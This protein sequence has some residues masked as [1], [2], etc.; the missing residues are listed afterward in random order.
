MLQRVKYSLLG[1]SMVAAV[2]AVPSAAT[3]AGAQAGWDGFDTTGVPTGVEAGDNTFPA[4]SAGVTNDLGGSAADL[5]VNNHAIK[6]E[7][8][9]DYT[10][11][12]TVFADAIPSAIA[13]LDTHGVTFTD[14]D[15]DGD[16]DLIEV[17]GRNP[18][19]GN[20]RNIV[21]RNN[22]GSLSLVGG[23]TG[24]EDAP[25]RGRHAVMVDIDLDGDMDAMI[26]NLDRTV[27]LDE[28]DNPLAA[29]PSELYLNNGDGTSWTKAADPSNAIGDENR[30]FAHV[31]S[32]GPGTP[33]AVITS[34]AFGVALDS[35][36]IGSATLAE[37][38]TP[39]RQTA[40]AA[41]NAT[42]I[43]DVA[44]G[45]LDGDLDPEFV[46]AR[47]DDF[48]NE[49]DLLGTL[50]I[51]VGQITRSNLV[52]L[53]IQAV[54]ND[55]L[56][57]SCRAVALADFD[58]DQ[59]LDIFG[60]CTFQEE[61]QNRNIVLLN[62]GSGN[63]S[64]ASSTQVP[65]TVTNTT[66][67]VVAGDFDNNGWVDTYSATGHD[68]QEGPDH[69][70]MNKGGNGNHWLKVDLVATNNPDAV[71][72][73]V[74]VGT[75]K[76]QVRE[77]GHRHHQG[78]DMRELHFGLGTNTAVAPLEIRWPDGTHETCTVA[79]VDRTVTVTQGGAGCVAQTASGQAA[80]LA[81]SP[82]LDKFCQG[83]LVTVD[84][85]AGQL[86]TNGDDVILGTSGADIVDAL[87]GNDLVCGLDGDD[88]ITGGVGD[89]R[90]YGDGGLDTVNGGDGNDLIWGGGGHD[91]LFGDGGN[92]VLRGSRGRDLIRG[93]DGKDRLWGQAGHDFLYGDAGH[94]TLL[95]QGGNDLMFGGDGRDDM[96]GIQGND[97][98]FGEGGAD[99]LRGGGGTNTL[100]GGDSIDACFRG[101]RVNCES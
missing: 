85:G 78:Q 10:G 4:W 74:F 96:W 66:T 69:L 13:D 83:E 97:R 15:G 57:D 59:D 43:R 89:D 77:S 56:A 70:F 91:R 19:G 53:A 58:N 73:Q 28:D 23:T 76:W 47:Q 84:L 63:F 94:D 18:D 65:A 30:R 68:N 101:S 7:A 95:G 61:G 26:V 9:I 25:G 41:N 99:T 21:W 3:P 27:L 88:Q 31:T 46:V 29:A 80:A 52:P 92:D 54:S 82:S 12:G 55:D 93:G 71:G 67:V 86:P 11:G 20:N 24:L 51:G 32:S 33:N 2:L 48:N 50:P 90:L 98:M 38:D 75:D 45:D 81:A 40:F 60:G 62:D 87:G 35:I 1:L 16:E 100:D 5:W 44:L 14:I 22:N 79:G 8:L 6:S 39:I 37:S 36:K 64:L 72:T 17:A 34:S 42:R 49:P